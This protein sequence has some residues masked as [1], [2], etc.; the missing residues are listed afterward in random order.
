[1]HLAKSEFTLKNLLGLRL[2]VQIKSI[3]PDLSRLSANY[4][5]R[6]FWRKSDLNGSSELHLFKRFE[7]V[8]CSLLVDLTRIRLPSTEEK[9]WDQK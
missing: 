5:F 4:I 8:A 9:H 3:E 7:S 6:R 2:I 1:M